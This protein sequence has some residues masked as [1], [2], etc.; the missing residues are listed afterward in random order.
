M[1]S[2]L[3]LF[4]DEHEFTIL[5][6]EVYFWKNILAEESFLLLPLEQK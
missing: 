2:D 6:T 4:R 3:E 5:K 1:E